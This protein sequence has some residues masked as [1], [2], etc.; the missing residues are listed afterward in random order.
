MFARCCGPAAVGQRSIRARTG[1]AFGGREARRRG[2]LLGA[3]ARSA[4]DAFL[5]AALMDACCRW[6]K[7]ATRL[8]PSAHALP[9]CLAPPGPQ[10][11][12]I[13]FIDEFDGIGKARSYGGGGND[14]SVHTINQLLTGGD[15][16]PPSLATPPVVLLGVALWVGRG[17]AAATHPPAGT[18]PWA[19]GPSADA[20]RLL[21][22]HDIRPCQQQRRCAAPAGRGALRRSPPLSLAFPI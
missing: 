3:G 13:L 12:C 6:R 9:R 11:P 1:A 19:R 14:E 22:V 20:V 18:C 10:A 8:R 5:G 17:A 21:S 4:G 15:L 7:R 16:P 2:L